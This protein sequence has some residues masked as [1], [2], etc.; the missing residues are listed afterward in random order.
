MS[1]TFNN[2]QNENN[3]AR[4]LKT[5]VMFAHVSFENEVEFTFLGLYYALTCVADLKR[6]I[7]RKNILTQ[8]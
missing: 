3:A 5:C 1:L 7:K 8:R 2:V 6:M 4:I